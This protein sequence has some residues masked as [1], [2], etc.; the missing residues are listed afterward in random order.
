[1]DQVIAVRLDSRQNNPYYDARFAGS[2]QQQGKDYMEAGVRVLNNAI[3]D[4]D[5]SNDI[6][7][8]LQ[9]CENATQFAALDRNSALAF[10]HPASFTQMLTLTTFVSQILFGAQQA[11]SVEAQGEDDA[12]KADDINAL[13][14]WNDAKISIYIQGFLWVWN[15]LV[16]NRGVW[17][18]DTDQDV[19]VTREPVEEDDISKPKV[20]LLKKDGTPVM[21]KGEPVMV[22]QKTQRMR[23]KRTRSG[24]FNC[25]HLVSP[26]D[27]ICDPEAPVKDFQ[28]GR[29]AGHRVRLTW[30]ELKRRSEL[31]PSDPMYVLPHVVMKI[32]NQGANAITPTSIGGPY[33]VTT[34]RTYW[35]RTLRGGG[36]NG[37]GIGGSGVGSAP[38]TDGV[39]KQDGGTVECWELFIR[40]KPKTLGMYDDEEF[41]II[42]LLMT[43]S[44]EVLSL[45]VQPNT[46]DE[47]PYAVAEGRPNGQRQYSPGWGLACKPIQDRIDNLNITHARAQA[48]MGNILVVD[49]TKCDVAN[50]LS[51]D[52]N[53]LLITRK[54]A[55]NGVPREDLV[56]Q[57][58]LQDVTANYNEEMA[59]WEKQMEAMTGAN[60]YTQGE[61]EDPSQTL[62]QFDATSRMAT[63]RI[64]SLARLISEQGLMP[65]TRR[66]VSNFQ[67]F[68]P[69]EMTVRVMGKGKDYDPNNPR[70]RYKTIKR[71]DILGSYDVVPHD[72]SLPGADSKIVAAAARTIEA[73]STNPALA[74][75]FDTSIPG[76][77]D[78]LKVFYDLLNKSGLPVE[79]YAVSTEEAQ[80][81]AQAKLAQAGVIQPGM[82]GA[83]VT[84]GP[85]PTAP[86]APVDA[87]GMPSAAVLPPNPSAA[88]TQLNGLTS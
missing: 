88:P 37:N 54:A 45:N 1:M 81:N 78:P 26:Y 70:P 66:F 64:S 40:A 28:K 44:G 8:M 27:F 16:F 2:I 11:R 63:G 77:I 61:T 18:E 4:F 12:D 57:I 86:P 5:A 55:G 34:S 79:K 82:P 52:K 75:A 67:Q 14:A 30:F 51:P 72:G 15:A 21:R 20:P 38:G 42:K 32:K 85:A 7:E 36:L 47:F 69:D 87:S 31:E 25:V 60:S 84:S 68:A 73:Y 17:Y 10:R 24:F 50:L 6:V 76:A 33:G 13:L 71:A 59:M 39:N 19:Q 43:S 62:G 80:R 9:P 3:A 41:E 83:P 46:H 22:F 56:D 49:E 35:E 65:Q 23:N 53:G 74:A 48:R 58:P 29:Y